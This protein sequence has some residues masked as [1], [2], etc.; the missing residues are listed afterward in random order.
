[1][2]KA[3]LVRKNKKTFIISYRHNLLAVMKFKLMSHVWKAV[4]ERKSESPVHYFYSSSFSTFVL[5]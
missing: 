2:E 1:M 5:V 4:S 3:T